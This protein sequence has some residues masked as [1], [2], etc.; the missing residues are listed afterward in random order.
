MEVPDHVLK[1]L[2]LSRSIQ[3]LAT[4]PSTTLTS[5]HSSST[6][7]FSTQ[8]SLVCS[9]LIFAYLHR[10]FFLRIPPRLLILLLV[11]KSMPFSRVV[12]KTTNKY[13]MLLRF[14]LLYFWQLYSIYF[15]LWLRVWSL[16]RIGVV[17]DLLL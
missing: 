6:F 11:E 4:Q 16:I 2:L 10:T 15:K 9:I 13:F 3:G 8:V 7:L 14:T 17:H 12:C 5:S 1:I